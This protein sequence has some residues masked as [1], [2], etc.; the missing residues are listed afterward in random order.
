LFNKCH[1]HAHLCAIGHLFG[2]GFT[3]HVRHL[4]KRLLSAVLSVRVRAYAFVYAQSGAMDV[5]TYIRDINVTRLMRDLAALS[6][7][8]LARDV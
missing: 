6:G 8:A 2:A 5:E 3:R 4:E 7:A 1:D